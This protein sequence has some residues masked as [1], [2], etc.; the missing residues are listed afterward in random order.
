MRTVALAAVL[1]FLAGCASP[2]PQAAP[3]STVPATVSATA[4]PSLAPVAAAAAER[5]TPVHWQGHTKEGAWVCQDQS[6]A[7]QCMAGQQVAPDG[8]FVTLVPYSG[9]LT[10]ANLTMTWQADPTQTGLAF[11]IFG[12]TTGGLQSLAFI[13]GASPL[14]LAFDASGAGLIPDGSLMLMVWPEGKTP[15]SPSVFVDLTQQAFTV[16]GTLTAW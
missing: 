6:G 15:T 7:G 9:N 4:T 14:V 16:D 8:Q 2:Q 5:T 10:Q 1:L 3:P 11:A 13:D 12:N